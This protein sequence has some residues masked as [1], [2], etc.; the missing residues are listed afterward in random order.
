MEISSQRWKP[1][2]TEWADL[3]PNFKGVVRSLD[4]HVWLDELARMC[5]QRFS[6]TYRSDMGVRKFYET[7]AANRKEHAREIHRL[8]EAE[9]INDWKNGVRSMHE[10][11]LILA[12]LLASLEDRLKGV[13]EK[14]VRS[15]ECE[16]NAAQ[17]VA[18]NNA[19]YAKI[20]PLMALMGKRENLLDA[21]ANLPSGTNDI[22]HPCR[23]V[24]LR[25]G[26]ASG[27]RHGMLQ[28]LK[29]DV[30]RIAS[31]ITEAVGR[32]D[33]ALAERCKEEDRDERARLQQQ[34]VR[35][36]RPQEVIDFARATDPRRSVAESAGQ[37]RSSGSHPSAW[38]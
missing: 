15:R 14:I 6:S 10:I 37:R 2:N 3:L 33:A 32:F 24:G 5:E 12:A 13:D 30:G 35:F 11:G 36:Y 22:P 21:Q 27:T 29:A 8:I 16:M 28:T 38:R 4:K 31:T 7:K 18:G 25:Q 9:L 1:I 19:E 20:G 26:A 17:K 23:S 34:L